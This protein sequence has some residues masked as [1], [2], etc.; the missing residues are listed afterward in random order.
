MI[1]RPL[2]YRAAADRVVNSP[3]MTDENHRLATSAQ[4]HLWM[5]FTRLTSDVADWHVP[6]IDHGEGCYVYDVHGRL[7]RELRRGL[8]P[9]GASSIRWDGTDGRGVLVAAG[10]YFYR[11]ESEGAFVTRKVVLLR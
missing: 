7:V 10:A 5:H 3:T 2:S 4:R 1:S 8:L 11:I 6:I 9:Q